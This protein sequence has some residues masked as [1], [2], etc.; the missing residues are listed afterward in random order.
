MQQEKNYRKDLRIEEG[1]DEIILKI[2]LNELEGESEY[3][4]VCYLNFLREKHSLNSKF[5]TIEPK[6]AQDLLEKKRH[7]NHVYEY[8]KEHGLSEGFLSTH[9]AVEKVL[10]SMAYTLDENYAMLLIKTLEKY[11]KI[12]NEDVKEIP[13]F[14]VNNFII[15]TDNVDF[16]EKNKNTGLS[17]QV[18]SHISNFYKLQY[19]KKHKIE[20][21]E[22][23]E[24]FRHANKTTAKA[25][26][27]EQNKYISPG[28]TKNKDWNIFSHLVQIS[29][30]AVD[31]NEVV[32]FEVRKNKIHQMILNDELQNTTEVRKR[33][34]P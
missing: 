1:K 4:K 24:V 19:C 10:N 33:V 34:R 18:L 25:F 12:W 32:E 28:N 29:D 17:L 9:R 27:F 13:R 20:P 8:I 2:N 3:V 7:D 31:T 6:E 5:F 14:K 23:K 11:A 26:N 15:S 22:V 21:Y 16:F 30:V